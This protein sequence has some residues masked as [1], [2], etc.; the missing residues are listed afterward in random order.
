MLSIIGRY[1]LRGEDDW[2]MSSV[3]ITVDDITHGPLGQ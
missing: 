3:L 2:L 1:S